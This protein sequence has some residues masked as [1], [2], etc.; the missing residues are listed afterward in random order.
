ML[1]LKYFAVI[2]QNKTKLR[3][4]KSFSHQNDTHTANLTFQ[5]F[6][7]FLQN[8]TKKIS[9]RSKKC[10]YHQNEQHSARGGQTFFPEGHMGHPVSIHRAA[11]KKL[12]LLDNK[13]KSNLLLH[14]T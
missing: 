2:D 1:L 14:E 10:F 9:L 11:L 6:D 5:L 3:S 4:K 12:N 8:L 13:I 7:T